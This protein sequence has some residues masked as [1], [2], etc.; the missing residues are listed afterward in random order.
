MSRVLYPDGTIGVAPKEHVFLT[1]MMKSG[2]V[3]IS[4]CLGLVLGWRRSTLGSWQQAG[5]IEHDINPFVAGTMLPQGAF[6]FHMHM[7]AWP[8]N[9]EILDAFKVRPIVLIRNVADIVMGV[10][11][12]CLK[13]FQADFDPKGLPGIYIPGS[14]DNMSREGQEL[15]LVDNLVPWL[16]SFHVS[17]KRQTT[18]PCLFVT[19]ETH[20]RDQ[21]PSFR[22]MLEWVGHGQEYP[23]NALERIANMKPHNFNKGV[24][25]RGKSMTERAMRRLREQIDG[26]GPTWA[27]ML[28]RDLL[29][30]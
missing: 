24:S 26:W 15:F 14:F 28:R 10:R 17:W 20:F 13:D 7:R 22:R 8:N 5:L 6:V 9:L 30:W 2:G 11:D 1:G 29:E 16:L 25:G 4:N 18:V 19:Y 3:H 12:N 21:V 27:P 23:E